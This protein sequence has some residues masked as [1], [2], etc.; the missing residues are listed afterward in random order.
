MP[1]Y[2][3]GKIYKI[4]N[5]QNETIYIGST[6]QTLSQR[7]CKHPHR[8]RG[9]KIILIEKYQCDCREELI[10]REQEIIEQYDN[11]LNKQRAYR[12]EEYHKQKEYR[13]KFKDKISEK[14]KI[15]VICECGCEIRKDALVKHKQTKKHI[16]LMIT[17][18]NYQ[19][20]SK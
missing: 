5:P 19:L 20:V 12:T 9:N 6:I 10:K 8:G 7:F 13:E 11:L 14:R 16:K 2:S 3:T 4:I 17:K 15:N 18:Y 1:D